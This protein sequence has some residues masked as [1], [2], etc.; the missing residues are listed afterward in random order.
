MTPVS[1]PI[2]PDE[3]DRIIREAIEIEL[4]T[5]INTENGL[6][7]NSSCKPLIHTLKERKKTLSNNKT[8]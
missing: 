7:L 2:N 6:S 3:L 1:W 4:H 5:K 8:F